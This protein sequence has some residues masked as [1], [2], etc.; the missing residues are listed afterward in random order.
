V[1]LVGS[2]VL[3]AVLGLTMDGRRLGVLANRMQVLDVPAAALLGLAVPIWKRIVSGWDE[4]RGPLRRALWPAGDWSLWRRITTFGS[5]VLAVAVAVPLTAV[6]VHGPSRTDAAPVRAGDCPA[7]GSAPDAGPRTCLMRYPGRLDERIGYLSTVPADRHVFGDDKPH[8][9]GRDTE[10]QQAEDRRFHDDQIRILQEN[11]NASVIAEKSSLRRGVV[12]VV[13]FAGLT[14]ALDDDYDSAEAEELEGLY[15]AQRYQN[16]SE[17]GPV[18]KIV[19]AN[20]GAHMFWADYVAQNM[21]VPLYRRDSSVLGVA[22]LDRSTSVTQAATALLDRA[23]IPAV[24]TTLSADGFAGGLTYYRQLSASN[25][26]EAEVVAD[27]ID[28]AVPAYFRLRKDLYNSDG[29][30]RPRRLTIY[31]PA[32]DPT[33]PRRGYH[34][35][36]LET[37]VRDLKAR[38]PG[39]TKGLTVSGPTPALD[40]RLCGAS[41]VVVYAGR[42]DQGDFSQFLDQMRTCRGEKVVT[43]RLPFV[44]ADDGITRFVADPDKRDPKYRDIEVSYVTKGID[45]LRTGTSCVTAKGAHAAPASLADLCPDYAAL[46][47]GT[48]WYAR[49]LWMGERVVLAYEAAQLFLAAVRNVPPSQAAAREGLR[50]APY[51]PRS[52]AVVRIPMDSRTARPGCEF[53]ATD[54]RLGGAGRLNGTERHP[55]PVL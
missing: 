20:G 38:L 3:L 14:T 15:L 9:P 26:R 7:G 54:H 29:K 16:D 39:R 13:Y 48:G 34:D 27:Y 53:D 19:I 50:R 52:L 28:R 35:L 40:D 17:R 36:Y 23:G 44:I 25:V 30:S 41:S 5:P 4:V 2:A 49:P 33:N 37:L 10:A 12:S 42:H 43:G 8:I 51:T 22:G 45:V 18:L 21:L 55:C 11:H 32:G 46:V 6:L 1:S 47:N 24:G 31:Q